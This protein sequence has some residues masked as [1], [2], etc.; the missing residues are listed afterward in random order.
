MLRAV[1]INSANAGDEALRRLYETAFPV[2]EQIPY[3]DIVAAL[4]AA[5]GKIPGQQ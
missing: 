5:W 4:R 1:A 2:G 3:A